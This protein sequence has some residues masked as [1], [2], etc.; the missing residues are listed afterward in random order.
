MQKILGLLGAL[1]LSA[2]LLVSGGAP[3]SA[4]PPPKDPFLAKILAAANDY[5]AANGAGPVVF[6]TTIATGSQQWADTLNGRINKDA[7]DMNKAHRS[8]AGRS[9]L[10][11][12]ADMYSEIIAIN[13]TAQQIVDWWM[14][15]ASHRAALLDKR[16]TDIGIGYV[17]TTKAGWSGMT[18]AV[19]NLAGYPAT[20][21]NQPAP[22]PM[23]VADDGDV[24]A[25]D[26]AGNLFI[27]GS[28]RGGDLWQRNFVSAGWAGTQQLEIADFNSDGLQDIIVKW[29]DGTL[30]VSY[31]QSDGTLK[32]PLRIGAGWAPY[33]MV[34]S[35]WRS[36]DKFPGIVAKYR[37]TGD[38]FYYPSPNG[39]GFSPR[40]TI[41]RD[42]GPLTILGTDFDG[43]GR[44]DIAARNPAGQLLLYRGD[45]SGGFVSEPRRVI[46]AGWGVMTHISGITNHLGTNAQ[47]ILARDRAGNLLHYPL[48][49]NRFVARTQIGTGGWSPLVLGS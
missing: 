3:A 2:A 16:A 1:A 25:V 21:A 42:W 46:G 39:S 19:A 41:G 30:T 20:R 22:P 9:I 33:D 36:T 44:A 13:N 43:D 6:N 11:Q 27:Y 15:S 29:Q 31:G 24:A 5:R 45:G 40:M 17:K 7:L 34:V 49:P 32:A 26:P 10:P 48:Q 8:D 37:P 28:A 14:G 47:G 35:K 4:A 12:G 23:P 18:V 38:L